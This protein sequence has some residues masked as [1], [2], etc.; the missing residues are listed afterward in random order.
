MGKKKE[1]RDSY[2]VGD[3]DEG[4]VDIEPPPPGWDDDGESQVGGD[5][6][7]AFVDES[8]KK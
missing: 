5:K 7:K 8:K 2:F 6:L 3:M 4:G 1:D